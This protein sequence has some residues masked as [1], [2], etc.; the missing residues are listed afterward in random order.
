[1]TNPD[2]GRWRPGDLIAG[3][4]SFAVLGAIAL[5][6]TTDARP[7]SSPLCL[8]RL[9]SELPCPFCGVTRSLLALGQGDY[10]ASIDY[11][12]LGLAMPAVALAILLRLGA[13]WVRG[14]PTRWPR[15]ALGA[16]A[17][18]V[19]VVWAT[20]LAEGPSWT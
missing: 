6:A 11:S 13:D 14:S 4:L 16:S 20:Q 1:V 8:F 9:V 15:K 19:V 10:G 17:L 5:G 12:P 18:V 2:A 7:E 3:I